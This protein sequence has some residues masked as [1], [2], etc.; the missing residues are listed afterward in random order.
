MKALGWIIVLIV[1]TLCISYLIDKIK[2]ALPWWL[3]NASILTS[4]PPYD[5]WTVAGII[6]ILLGGIALALIIR[7]EIGG[8]IK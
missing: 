8:P 6:I 5:I 1:A 2:S 7:E 4:R 3:R